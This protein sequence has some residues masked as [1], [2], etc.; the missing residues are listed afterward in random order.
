[1]TL[2]KIDKPT[3]QT[4]EKNKNQVYVFDTVYIQLTQKTELKDQFTLGCNLL[5]VSQ[6]RSFAAI[7]FKLRHG[8][9]LN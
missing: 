6:N 5:Q 2:S 3:E 8:S 9:L 7:H 1:M 4:I